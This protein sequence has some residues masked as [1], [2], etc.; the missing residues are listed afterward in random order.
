[1]KILNKLLGKFAFVPRNRSARAEGVE[2]YASSPSGTKNAG[3][4]K[5]YEENRREIVLGEVPVRY[6]EIARMT[7]GEHVMELGSADGTQCLV[8]AKRKARVVGVELMQMQYEEAENLKAA[9]AARGERTENCV[10]LNA[11]I[12]S[13]EDM[14]DGFDTILMSRVL[15]HLRGKADPLVKR[16]SSSKVRYLVLVGC[17]ERTRR[18]R[19]SGETGDAMGKYAYLATKEGMEEILTKNGFSIVNSEWSDENKDP[20]VVGEKKIND[21]F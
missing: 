8:L 10:Y 11:D 7:P 16:I 6:E 14:F 21:S 9:W 5:Y 12:S 4:Q 2:Y 13:V 18:W 19:S 17:P 1:M 3:F 15:Y 20:V